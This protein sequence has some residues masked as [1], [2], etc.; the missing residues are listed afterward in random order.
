MYNLYTDGGSRANT[1]AAC[2]W[3]VTDDQ[4]KVL[5]TNATY[6]GSQTNNAAEYL[7]LI[8]GLP[9]AFAGGIKEL[10]VYQDSELVS[11]Q[12][13][14]QY[15]VK[16]E[17]LKPLHATAKHLASQFDTI[18]FKSVPREDP[19]ISKCDEMCDSVISVYLKNS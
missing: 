16:A 4:G 19:I 1:H 3:L 6:L 7:G 15:Q 10:T 12:M 14:G 13:T 5:H 17:H 18:V 9:S 11:R 2:A 8:L